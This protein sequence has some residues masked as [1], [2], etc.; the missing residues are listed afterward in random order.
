MK[1]FLSVKSA[2]AEKI[3]NIL[4]DEYFFSRISNAKKYIILFF[5]AGIQYLEE[6]SACL[7]LDPK[8]Y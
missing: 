3:I 4:K 5:V 7:A 6:L 2:I 1:I 8:A